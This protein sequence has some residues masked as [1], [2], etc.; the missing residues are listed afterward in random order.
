MKQKVDKTP[1]WAE[2]LVQ[3][4]VDKQ[5]DQWREEGSFRRISTYWIEWYKEPDHSKSWGDCWSNYRGYRI[6]IHA[7]TSGKDLKMVLLHEVAHMIAGNSEHHSEKFWEVA[8]RLY[9]EIG[10][11]LSYAISREKDYKMTAL[12]GYHKALG[13]TDEQIKRVMRRE[14]RARRAK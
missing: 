12:V 7:G 8:F 3:E 1:R 14:R 11:S 10:I 4:I 2:R 6:R 9:K 13:K 5:N